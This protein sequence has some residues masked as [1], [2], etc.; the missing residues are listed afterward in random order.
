MKTP[1]H[2]AKIGL[3]QSSPSS[4]EVGTKPTRREFIRGAAGAS[5]LLAGSN[6]AAWADHHGHA[7]P[8]S[9]S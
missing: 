3:N 2:A 1:R 5:V 7:T 4:L 9:L 6:V 8:Q